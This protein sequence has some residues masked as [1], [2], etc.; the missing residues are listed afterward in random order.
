MDQLQALQVLY[1]TSQ[2]QQEV[3]QREHGRL[4]EER[5]R[6]QAELQLCMEEMQV[7]QTQSPMI[8]R[9]FEYCGKNSGSR[10][11]S[12]ENFHRSYESSIDEMRAIRRVM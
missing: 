7:L 2:K 3:L 10:A 4:M 1:D 11:P 12:T 9:S 5:K 6:L 8:K